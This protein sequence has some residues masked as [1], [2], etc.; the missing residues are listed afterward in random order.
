MPGAPTQLGGQPGAHS[1]PGG[2]ARAKMMGSPPDSRAFPYIKPIQCRPP[3]RDHE[4]SGCTDVMARRAARS[5]VA[6]R[7]GRI[8]GPVT[9][10]DFSPPR[11]DV[12][13]LAE[14]ATPRRGRCESVTARLSNRAVGAQG[15]DGGDGL[16]NGSG[17]GGLGG[18]IYA[19]A[20]TTT[21][22]SGS[23]FDGNRAAGGRGGDGGTGV[24]NGTG[25]AGGGGAVAVA[26][27]GRDASLTVAGS[28]FIDSTA[29]GGDGGN[30]VGATYANGFGG[31][32][33]G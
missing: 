31:Q 25:G 11:I 20:G 6:R 17:G 29:Q 26:V 3:C 28:Q 33:S 22:I 16:V 8:A 15:V 2:E 32:G 13:H 24:F 21:R 4:W 7:A 23:R 18:A 9:A 10:L 12:R 30:G 19:D 5:A 1:H 14:R 27:L